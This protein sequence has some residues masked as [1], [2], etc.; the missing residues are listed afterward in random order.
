MKTCEKP[1]LRKICGCSC[2]AYKTLARNCN[3][4]QEGAFG[5]QR[6][7]VA[8]IHNYLG[9]LQMQSSSFRKNFLD[10]ESLLYRF[11]SNKCKKVSS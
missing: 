2:S 6:K 3:W 10:F 8:S 9:G 11:D 1:L 4:E 5:I 7:Y